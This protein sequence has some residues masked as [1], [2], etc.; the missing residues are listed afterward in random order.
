VPVAIGL[1]MSGDYTRAII[2]AVVGQFL[3]SSIDGFLRPFLVGQRAKLH[4]LVIF[5]SVLGGLRYFGLLGILLGPVVMAL[6]YALL[7]VVMKFDGEAKET[8]APG[9]LSALS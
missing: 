4:E 2:L 5:F 7:S 9:S 8:A 1:A 3:I 6:T